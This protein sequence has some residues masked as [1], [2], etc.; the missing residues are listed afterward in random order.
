MNWKKSCRGD[1]SGRR[2]DLGKKIKKLR[3]HSL[4]FPKDCRARL[5]IAKANWG[6]LS[7]FEICHFDDYS[8]KISEKHY[9]YSHDRNKHVFK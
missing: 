4:T 2:A 3:K 5:L 1:P 7:Y 6:C 8:L 9:I